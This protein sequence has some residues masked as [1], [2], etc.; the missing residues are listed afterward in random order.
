MVIP[1]QSSS[2]KPESPPISKASRKLSELNQVL[3]VVLPVRYAAFVVRHL[4]PKAD[5]RNLTSLEVLVMAA[6]RAGIGSAY[7]L[8]TRLGLSVAATLPLLARL[9]R[10]GWLEVKS[11]PRNVRNYQL[12]SK[13]SS[14]LRAGWRELLASVP[15]DLEGIMRVAYVA[16][17]I[18]PDPE[19][20][21]AFL[22]RA[23]SDR[24]DRANQR[25]DEARRL[26][27][28]PVNFGRGHKW[29]RATVEADQL[30]A[31]SRALSRIATQRN[32]G[33]LL[34]PN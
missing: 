18:G 32:L 8:N 13:G 33:K 15:R 1:P 21:R 31:E 30:R 25:A 20:C 24:K 28:E 16:A 34:A 2:V 23:A 12:T 14:I 17:A 26:V 27:A 9:E 3:L 6:A 11:G 7:A 4:S 22:R 29:L 5:R 19:V 10:A